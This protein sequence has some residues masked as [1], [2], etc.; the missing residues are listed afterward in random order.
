MEEVSLRRN[1]YD[2]SVDYNSIDKSR[3]LKGKKMKI[4]ANSSVLT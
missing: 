2:F 4:V 3:D 1:V